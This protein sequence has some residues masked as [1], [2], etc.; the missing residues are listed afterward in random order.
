MGWLKRYAQAA[1]T[2]SVPC[3]WEETSTPS[4]TTPFDDET[5]LLVGLE[6]LA[7]VDSGSFEQYLGIHRGDYLNYEIGAA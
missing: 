2:V 4:N 7:I 6:D 3:V 1:V 5:C